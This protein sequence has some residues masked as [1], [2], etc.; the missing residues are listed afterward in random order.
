MKTI[1]K[2]AQ[3]EL[4]NLFFSPI[5]WFLSVVFTIQ[6]GYFFSSLVA[7]SAKDQELYVQSPLFKDWG[8]SLTKLVFLFPNATFPNVIQNL[9]LFIPLLTMGILSREVNS[10]SI[11]LLY[12][13]PIK[14]SQ[15]VFGKYL[16]MVIFNLILVGIVG[17]LLVISF[18]EIKSVDY[19]LLIS[20]A[21]GFFLLTCAY[22]AIGLFMSSL[23]SYQIVSAI[24]TFMTIFIL[25]K[26]GTLWQ[27]ID[28]VRD[29]TYF[30]SISGRTDKMLYGLVTT[31]DVVYFLVVIGMFVGFTILKLRSTRESN[32]WYITMGKYLGILGVALFIGYFSS[33][34]GLIGY[35]DA[36][37]S[38]SNTIHPR[39]QE[40]VKSLGDEPLEVTLYTNLLDFSVGYGLPQNRNNYLSELWENYLRFNPNIKFKYEYYYALKPGDQLYK[41]YPDKNIKQIAQEVAKALDQN[42]DRFRTPE[43]MRKIIDLEAEDY[44]LIMKLKYKGKTTFLRTFIQ[45]VWPREEQVAA[46]LSRLLKD[47]MPTVLVTTGN[48]ERRIDVK[49]ERGYSQS[50]SDKLG[51]TALINN[52]FDVDTISLDKNDIPYDSLNIA[53][54]VLADPKTELSKMVK[55]KIQQYVDKGGSLMILGEPGKEDILNPILKPLGVEFA[56]GILVQVSKNNPPDI[57]TP[58]LTNDAVNMAEENYLLLLKNRDIDS[59]KIKMESATSITVLNN[60][61][62]TIRPLALTVPGVWL[63]KGGLVRDSVPPTLNPAEGDSQS[64]S[65]ATAVSLTR[66]TNSGEQRI[67]V[68]GDADFLSNK[69]RGGLIQGGNIGRGLYSWLDHNEFPKYGP[70]PPNRDNLFTISYA[71]AFIQKVILIW[72]LPSLIGIAGLILIIRRKRN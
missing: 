70:Q 2:I 33:R 26:I 29:L 58:Y 11:K 49:G 34:A 52:G 63:K 1:L 18:F 21:M 53:A 48:L 10:G 40:I 54:L 38:K 64:R 9:Y 41:T 44:R 50:I 17:I 23:T 66:K 37:N 47:K 8:T 55:Q 42:L 25:S 12:S 35:W 4:R 7:R 39:V 46:A 60:N 62:F 72:V 22:A 13:S 19:G 6:T 5:A 67:L 59:I 24:A 61:S 32:R 30:L 57:I 3:A 36:T 16:S 15:I 14:T 65:Y 28:F 20:A 71:S 56:K 27:N 51:M 45:P 69:E 31:K 43:E 68:V